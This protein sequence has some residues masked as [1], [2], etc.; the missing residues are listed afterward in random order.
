MPH[1]RPPLSQLVVFVCIMG[2]KPPYRI[3]YCYTNPLTRQTYP[4]S[5]PSP[6]CDVTGFSPFDVVF[7]LDY[8]STLGGWRFRRHVEPRTSSPRIPYRRADN[9]LSMTTMYRTIDT[10]YKFYLLFR[11]KFSGHV[12][13]D[14]PQEGNVPPPQSAA[15]LTSPPPTPTPQPKADVPAAKK[16]KAKS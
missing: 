4:L 1:E 10:N 3:G 7:A 14:D 8:M 6:T 15:S 16:R 13:H 11:N 5:S 12:C 9:R 2:D